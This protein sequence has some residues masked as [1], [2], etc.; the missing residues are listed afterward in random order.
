MASSATFASD[1][2][3]DR[4][5]LVGVEGLHVD[6]Q[7]PARRV[8]EQRPGAGGEVL[9]P[10]ADTDHQIGR[11]A[12]DVGAGRTGH[13]DRAEIQRV[14]EVH[15]RLARLR[16]D[17][18]DAMRRGKGGKSGLGLGVD[19]PAACDDHGLLCGPDGGDG[20]GEFG[21]VGFRAADAPDLR[22]KEAFGIVEGL[23]LHVL[24]EGQRDRAALGRVGHRP[25]GTRQRRQKLFGPHDPVEISRDGA[26]AV[27]HRDRAVAE[28]LGLLQHRVGGA[29]G[30]DVAGNEQNRQAVDMR[31]ARRRHHVQRARTDRRGD[32]HRL[33]PLRRLGIGDGGMG[34]RLLIMAAPG[35]QNVAHAVQRLAD[36]RHVAMTEDRP[37]TLDEA[38]AILGLLHR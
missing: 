3:V 21:R 22:R 29:V 17:N 14:V 37:D 30:K 9:E 13:T 38:V 2:E 28:I 34:H 24:T 20:R 12:D 26:E 27:V 5:V 25:Q 36:A 8:L 32:S 18:G 23:G 35:W 11:L 16:F 15:H 19:H 6:R 10:R 7:Q 1:D 4:A 33:A 31:K